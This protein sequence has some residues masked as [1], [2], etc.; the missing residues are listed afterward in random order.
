MYD[1]LTVFH[2]KLNPWDL[3]WGRDPVTKMRRF[4]WWTNNID[5]TKNEAVIYAFYVPDEIKVMV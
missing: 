2:G 5:L 3:I 1:N 4:L